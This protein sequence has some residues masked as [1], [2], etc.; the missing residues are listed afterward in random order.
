MP[1][2][3]PTINGIVK[4]L[5]K[6]GRQLDAKQIEIQELDEASVRAKS[7]YE[8]AYARSF[9]SG[10]GSVDARK[11]AAV[12]ATEQQKL[13]SEIAEQQL[14]AAKESIRVLRDRLEIGRSLNAA[15]KSEW[16]AGSVG[17]S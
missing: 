4:T 12:L 15:I 10:E 2:V 17:Q 9:L 8:V 16:T 7:R 3:P 1:D 6:L 13:D 11:Q 14:R 5:S